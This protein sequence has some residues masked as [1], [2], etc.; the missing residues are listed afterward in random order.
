M[1]GAWEPS[2]LAGSSGTGSP[3]GPPMVKISNSNMVSGASQRDAGLATHFWDAW[4]RAS[5]RGGRRIARVQLLHAH[6]TRPRPRHLAIC[7]CL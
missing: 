1:S 2:V 6:R 3:T 7:L 4:R 5:D